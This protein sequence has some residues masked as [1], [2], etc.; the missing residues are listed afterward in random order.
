VSFDLAGTLGSALGSNLRLLID[1]DGDG[2][3][4]N[5]VTPVA[6]S[7]SGTTVTFSGINFQNGDRFTIGNTNISLPLPIELLSFDASV[8]Q[9]EVLL[10]WATASELNNDYF[11]VQRSQS[12]ESWE[13][14]EEIKG[15]PE[16][17]VRIDYQATD[18]KP[19]IG[20][21]YYR[22][23]Q[24]DYD[25][26]STYSSIKR[27]QVD[28]SYQLKAYPNP[29]TGKLTVTT[30]FNLEP[31]DIRL[32]NTIGQQ[33]PIL[34]H[35]HGGEAQIEAINPPPGIYILQVLLATITSNQD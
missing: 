14:I 10:Q 35:Q 33:V 2:F 31:Q 32:L 20:V 30:G 29:T 1:R 21:S 23:K 22:L 9:N 27:V 17:Q 13:A 8:I 7:F 25:G 28:E 34:I 26:T 3:A 18:T 24:T 11:T 4:D 12:G 16:S 6:G 5:D 15:S 19:H